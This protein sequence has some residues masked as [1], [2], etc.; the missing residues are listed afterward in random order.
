MVEGGS[1]GMGRP[2][3]SVSSARIPCSKISK[4]GSGSGSGLKGQGRR[5][6][7][8]KEMDKVRELEGKVDALCILDFKVNV[9]FSFLHSCTRFYW[10]S[11][12]ADRDPE[13]I[14]LQEEETPGWI[15][16]IQRPSV[17]MMIGNAMT[18]RVIDS[19]MILVE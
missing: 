2:I 1:K 19:L 14:K 16:L 12:K 10:K 18:C 5:N 8:I 15:A 7:E 4:S 9:S 13:V 3:G 17:M 11:C 6:I